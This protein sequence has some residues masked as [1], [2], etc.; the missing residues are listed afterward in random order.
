MRLRPAGLMVCLGSKLLDWGSIL[1]PYNFLMRFRMLP[2][3]KQLPKFNIMGL[4]FA[5]ERFYLCCR[6]ASMDHAHAQAY[7]LVR[8]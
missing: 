5:A 8:R 3:Q 1:H 2:I 6:Q 7:L 4:Q